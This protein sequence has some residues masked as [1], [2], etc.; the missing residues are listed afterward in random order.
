MCCRVSAFKF[1]GF[2]GRQKFWM[3]QAELR[4]CLSEKQKLFS[5]AL[6]RNASRRSNVCPLSSESTRHCIEIGDSF[7]IA[8]E[9]SQKPPAS[10]LCHLRFQRDLWILITAIHL[11]ERVRDHRFN[12]WVGSAFQMKDPGQSR[13]YLVQIGK[14]GLFL[15]CATLATLAI[16]GEMLEPNG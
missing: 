5:N 6:T 11:S 4:I 2:N 9:G 8:L 16:F 13:A 14:T 1:D 12:F 3:F 15:H 7:S 10:N